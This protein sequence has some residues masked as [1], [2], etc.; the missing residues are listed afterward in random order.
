MFMKSSKPCRKFQEGECWRG[1]DCKFSH[2]QSE[3][4]SPADD[5]PDE[6]NIE[7][8]MEYAC[9]FD[10]TREM[11]VEA[12]KATY[13][14]ELLDEEG[15]PDFRGIE[16]MRYLEA[17]AESDEASALVWAAA[18]SAGP[19]VVRQQAAEEEPSVACQQTTAEVRSWSSAPP[20]VTSRRL[21][22]GTQP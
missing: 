2:E 4:A 10:C 8:V 15:Y 20:W 5:E 13:D 18:K 12:L 19:S 6:G 7:F 1:A 16:A 14:G 17:L 9:I 11:A 21:V 22:G 3:P